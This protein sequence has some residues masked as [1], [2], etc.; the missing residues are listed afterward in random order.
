MF[1][2]SIYLIPLLPA[3]GAAM[4]FFFGRRLDPESSDPQLYVNE[5]SNGVFSLL[6]K[7]YASRRTRAL[8]ATLAPCVFSSSRALAEVDIS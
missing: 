2:D 4:M 1:L 7:D 6:Q 8:A 5:C 3:F